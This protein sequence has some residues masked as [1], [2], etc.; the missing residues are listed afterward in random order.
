MATVYGLNQVAKVLHI[1]VECVGGGS[2]RSTS[3]MELVLRLKGPSDPD[4][5][6]RR[7]VGAGGVW[8]T[9]QFELTRG[10]KLEHLLHNPQSKDAIVLALQQVYG[11]A[12]MDEAPLLVLSN[13]DCTVFQK[14]SPNVMDKRLWASEPVWWDS[15]RPSARACWLQAFQTAKG[16]ADWCLPRQAVPQTLGGCSIPIPQLEPL[17]PQQPLKR[18]FQ[19]QG[20]A[21]GLADGSAAAYIASE[22]ELSF[23]ELGVTDAILGEGQHGRTLLGQVNG[24]QYA[25]K[26]YNI[27]LPEA[28]PAYHNE[29]HCLN[30]LQ[31]CPGVVQLH[32]AGRLQETAYPCIVTVAAG[33]PCQCLSG[34]Q[35]I[36]ARQAILQLHGAGAAHG[37]I[38]LSNILFNTDDKCKL[39]D[40]AHCTLE[41][42]EQSKAKDLEWLKAL[43]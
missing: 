30:A 2:G 4:H 14:R 39:V 25:V 33:N 7:I 24:K 31:D 28:I 27:R 19:E 11:D 42:D 20:K 22:A 38:R 32:A 5:M 9:W 10:S 3:F 21:F 23:Q 6:S 17:E 26:L 41:A 35:R 36:A 12:V 13:Y 15:Q 37:D 18:K 8:G 29:K 40:F 43:P 16:M 1:G 34:Q